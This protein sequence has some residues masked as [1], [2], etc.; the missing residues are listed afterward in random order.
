MAEAK[1]RD[2]DGAQLSEGATV[3]VD[4]TDGPR[5]GQVKHL[6]EDRYG[7]YAA[8]DFGD[9]LTLSEN[10]G[11]DDRCPDLVLLDDNEKEAAGDA[12]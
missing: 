3:E 2:R 4:W 7:K 9:S 1:V 12:G 6:I 10:A 8:I 11:S 5:T